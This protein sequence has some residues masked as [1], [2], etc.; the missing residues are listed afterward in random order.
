MSFDLLGDVNY[1]AALVA[2]VVWFILGAIW[3]APPVFGRPWQRAI[4]LETVEGPN[5]MVFVVTFVV[6]LVTTVA[7]AMLAAAT[8][9]DT[10]AEGL[11][12]GVV[13]GVGFAVA[14]TAVGAVYEPKPNRGTWFWITGVY[15]LLAYVVVAIIL[16][17][18]P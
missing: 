1:L 2:A 8:G 16:A 7:L 9:T 14:L 4:G 3:Y 11:V 10:L 12:L 18:W 5:P 13:T 6:Y 17:L 15:N